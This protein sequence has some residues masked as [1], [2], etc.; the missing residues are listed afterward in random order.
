MAIYERVYALFV[1]K[2]ALPQDYSLYFISSATE[3]WDILNREFASKKSL[4]LFNG[5]FG[6]K[7]FNW[8]KKVYPKMTFSCP[9]NEN[10]LPQLGDITQDYDLICATHCETSNASFLP[11]S[12]LFS[13]RE[14]YKEKIIAIDATSS[15]GGLSCQWHLADIWFCS[16]QKCLGL[17]A[18]MGLL[19]VNRNIFEKEP[20]PNL[21][22]NSLREME[23]HAKNYQTHFTPNVLSVFLLQK[24][25]ESRPKIDFV[26]QKLQKRSLKMY[27][28]MTELGFL[29]MLKNENLRSSTVFSFWFEQNEL[30]NL[31]Q[32]ANELDLILGK[33]YG[34]YQEKSFRMANFPQYME[35]DFAQL[36][37]FFTNF[38]QEKAKN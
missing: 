20:L 6:E 8:R 4:H 15:L 11:D 37:H 19:F 22:Y 35:A 38:V 3:A 26:S 31:H 5:A 16:V 23:K 34:Q 25:L 10:E 33:G 21:F 18:G 36:L 30:L 17:P 24:A 14:K 7:W 13:L 28:K 1:E 27:Q 32:K 2:L 9:F 29:P 12:F